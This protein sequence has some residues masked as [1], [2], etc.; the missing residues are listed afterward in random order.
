VATQ[1]EEV[2][3]QIDDLLRTL[4]NQK[5]TQINVKVKFLSVEN[6]LLEQIGVNWQNFSNPGLQNATPTGV[7]TNSVTGPPSGTLATAGQQVGGYWGNGNI[8]S[9]AN[10]T[11]T[12]TAFTTA[13]SIPAATGGLTFKSQ[14]WRVAGD[15]YAAALLTAVEQTRRGNVIFEPDV[16]FF[17]G[18]QAHILHINQQAYIGDY[19]VN[20]AQ[21]DPIISTLS[22]GTVL[23]VRGIASADKKY[24]TLTMRPTNAV[25]AAWRRFGPALAANN[26]GTLDGVS[27][28]GS[29]GNASG[30]G[31]AGN[32]LLIPQLRYNT[33]RTSVTV[34]DGGSLVLAGMVNG[35]SARS[36]AG[37]PFLS[38]IPFLGR[39]FSNN[40]RTETEMKTFIILRAKLVIFEEIE[41]KL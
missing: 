15:S 24:I 14:Y 9:A 23:D 12:L 40:G 33:V 6:S 37:I 27:T 21:Y 4:R 20:Q 5:G 17:N 39:L 8:V 38:H 18:Q 29:G 28:T 25:V 10:V 31:G 2:H 35:E 41:R 36:H 26:G 19:D 13:N 22:Y 7:S 16:T 3:K 1:T 11:N 30:I 34:P 32:P